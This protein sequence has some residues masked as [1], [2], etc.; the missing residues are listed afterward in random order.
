ML[1]ELVALT[2]A[3]FIQ[4]KFDNIY[5][6]DYPRSLVEVIVIDSASDD[7]TAGLVKKWTYEHRDLDLRLVEEFRRHGMVPALNYVLQ[8][9]RIGREVLRLNAS[10]IPYSHAIRFKCTR[11]R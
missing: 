5:G 3:K 8:H 2:L 6:Q 10:P 9:Y 1:L 11:I 4:Q 7:G